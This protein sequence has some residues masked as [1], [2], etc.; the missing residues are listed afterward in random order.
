[1]LSRYTGDGI[2]G[3]RIADGLSNSSGRVEVFVNGAWGTVCDDSWDLPDAMVAC[4][5]LGYQAA[6]AVPRRAFFGNGTGP[7]WMD[8]VQCGGFEISLS[9]CSQ[10]LLAKHNCHHSEDA[11][12]VCGGKDTRV[13]FKETNR[14]YTYL[15]N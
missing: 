5:Q 14:N 8:D 9:K 11:G 2:Q 10:P 15:G 4:K 3:I 7:I 6:I 12:V 1:M 13:L